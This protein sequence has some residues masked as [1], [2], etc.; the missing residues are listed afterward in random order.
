MGRIFDVVQKYRVERAQP[1][2]AAGIHLLQK[3]LP[4]DAGAQAKLPPPGGVE[5]LPESRR[6]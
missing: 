6:I 2:E 3:V 5:G 1:D 4:E